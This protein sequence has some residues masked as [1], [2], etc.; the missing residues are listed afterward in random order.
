MD[1]HL[2]PVAGNRVSGHLARILVP[3]PMRCHSRPEADRYEEGHKDSRNRR[4]RT[5]TVAVTTP[6]MRAALNLVQVSRRSQ[7]C[8]AIW[9][10]LQYPRARLTRRP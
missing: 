4:S 6:R 2:L 1:P 10:S 5:I 7:R 3:A 9:V 8:A